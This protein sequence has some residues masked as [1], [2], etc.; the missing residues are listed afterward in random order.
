[1]KKNDWILISAVTSY[2]FLFYRELP[3]INVLLFSMVLMVALWIR[4]KQ[5]TKNRQWWAA[6]VGT[7]ITAI[8]V[9]VYGN[10]LSV[11][12]NVISLCVLSFTSMSPKSSVLMGIFSSLYSAGGSWMF[13]PTDAVDRYNKSSK[14]DII[15]G[16]KSVLLVLIPVLVALLFFA[17]Y[18]A[19]NPAFSAL[20]KDINF[21]FISAP[22]IFFTL[23]GVFLLYGFFYHQKIPWLSLK[24]LEAKNEIDRNAEPG[25]IE[26]L[27]GLITENTSGIVLLAILNFILLSVNIIDINYLYFK[28]ELPEG[29]TYSEYVHQGVGALIMSIV[30]AISIILFYFRGRLNYY[31][32]NGPIKWLAL[33][34][35]VQNAILVI[36]TTY[37]NQL[38]IDVFSLTYKRIGVY[39]YLLLTLIGLIITIVK[40]VRIRSNWF[41]VRTTGWA[42]YT[43]LVVSCGFSWNTIV[44]EFNIE[45]AL[46]ENKPL[47]QRYLLSLGDDVLPYVLE[48]RQHANPASLEEFQTIELK[49]SINRFLANW[50]AVSWKSWSYSKDK[51]YRE[52]K[53]L[54]AESEYQALRS[55]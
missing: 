41:M 24:D 4:N 34:W 43:V 25:K 44:A 42:F 45:K 48:Y 2:S 28:V 23:S 19:A 29:V 50:E 21:D 47:D 52:L 9:A 36:S 3:G 31:H 54:K 15:A 32:K 6:V 14:E 49:N 38:Y 26:Q 20:T 39:V 40:I 35:V 16:W 7:L 5:V 33:L 37:R 1:M 55:Y 11:I 17:L 27:V 18:R 13:I 30:L 8:C 10:A 53:Q 12:G 51:T 22:W 46:R